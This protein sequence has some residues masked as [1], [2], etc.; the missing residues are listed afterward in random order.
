M[1]TKKVDIRT[2]KEFVRKKFSPSSVVRRII[3]QEKDIISI[4]SFVAKS[5]IWLRLVDEEQENQ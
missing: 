4:N 3:L 1:V 5:E 2:L